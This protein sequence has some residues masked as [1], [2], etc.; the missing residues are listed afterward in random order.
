M[1]KVQNIDSIKARTRVRQAEPRVKLQA[2]D[3]ALLAGWYALPE[4]YRVAVR[5]MVR[6]AIQASQRRNAQRG[7]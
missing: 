7:A 2:T 6:M 1:Q 3:A 4:G 5:R